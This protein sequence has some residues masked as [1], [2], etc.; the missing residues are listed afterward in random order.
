MTASSMLPQ[1][2]EPGDT[3]SNPHDVD[4][5]LPLRPVNSLGSMLLSER[6]EPQCTDLQTSRSGELRNPYLDLPQLSTYASNPASAGIAGPQRPRAIAP[7]RAWCEISQSVD[8][9]RE[10]RVRGLSLPDALA[11]LDGGP[12]MRFEVAFGQTGWSTGNRLFYECEVRQPRCTIQNGIVALLTPAT[13]Y[14]V[15]GTAPNAPYR[16]QRFAGG[17]AAA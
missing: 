14:S 2:W 12:P 4:V 7:T 11:L 17:F 16:V 3:N 9:V 13:L 1:V 15:Q 6:G 10:L 8:L 5:P